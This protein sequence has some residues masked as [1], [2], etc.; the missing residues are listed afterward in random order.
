VDRFSKAMEATNDSKL[1]VTIVHAP[2][3]APHDIGAG[4]FLE[5]LK[6]LQQEKQLLEMER[7][8]AILKEQKK[9]NWKVRQSPL[10]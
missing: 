6:A 5:R 1:S 2:P 9:S 8:V 10:P 4:P 7:D 3:P